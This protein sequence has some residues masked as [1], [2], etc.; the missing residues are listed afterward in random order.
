MSLFTQLQEKLQG[1]LYNGYFSCCCPFHDDHSPSCFVNESGYRCKSCGAHGSL[2]YLNKY[3]GGHEI[4]IVKGKSQVLPAWKSWEQRWG[5]LQGIADH[6]HETCKRFPSEMW[7]MRERKID[8]FFELGY[9]G[10]ADNWMLFPV[11]DNKHKIQ[12]IVVR[13][14]KKKDVRYAIKHIEENKP[15]LYCPNWQRVQ[16]SDTI[17]VPFG[18]IDSW[19]FEAI[20][21]ASVTGIT[22]KSLSAELLAPLNKKIVFVP[23]EGEEKEAHQLANKLGWKAKVRQLVYG[24]GEK[25][26]D[27][28]RRVHGNDYL[29]SLIGVTA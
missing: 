14:T 17:Y 22:G 18:V 3:L 16:E 26:P 23:D 21:L 24:D 28:V 5:D 29:L 7:Y 13:H 9:F 27:N 4:K 20:N 1:H 6:A 10:M 8:Q 19:S 12:S 15:L 11:F 2:E 25:D